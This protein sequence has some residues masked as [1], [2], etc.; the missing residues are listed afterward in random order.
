[1]LGLSAPSA[2][3]APFGAT[4]PSLPPGVPS[5]PLKPVIDGRLTHAAEWESA[6][7]L[8]LIGTAAMQ[9]SVGVYT[10]EVLFGRHGEDLYLLAAVDPR[11]QEGLWFEVL[12][13]VKTG[14]Q[15]SVA[16]ATLQKD[17][18]AM[19][20]AFCECVSPSDVHV[21]WD[22]V[23]EMACLQLFWCMRMRSRCSLGWG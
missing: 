8:S 15:V 6:G 2:L 14:E 20:D 9:S 21:V 12:S 13:S 16:R 4:S 19:V 18:A 17:G 1:M 11:P 22:E 3:S 23:V 10:T 5:A 7:R